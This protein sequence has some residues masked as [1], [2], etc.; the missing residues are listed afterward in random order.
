[1][2]N[3]IKNQRGR[4]KGTPKT[5]G[6]RKGTPN[7]VTTDLRTFIADVIDANREQ[8]QRDMAFLD[9]KDRLN[10]IER[11]LAYVIPKRTESSL[12]ASILDF[13]TI[14]DEQLEEVIEE[15]SLRINGE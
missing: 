11:L 9:P 8:M 12:N 14:T 10:V 6:R 7:K 4:R 5:G 15:L 13:S 2:E 1:M 3:S